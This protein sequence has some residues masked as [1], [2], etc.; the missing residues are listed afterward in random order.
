MSHTRTHYQPAAVAH[1]SIMKPRAYPCDQLGIC[2]C[3]GRPCLNCQPQPASLLERAGLGGLALITLV[4]FA[5][6][7]GWLWGT[8]ER[9]L[10]HLWW[11]FLSLVS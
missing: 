5:G 6:A 4:I 9:A 3:M 2:D 11:S 8:Y 1:T 10:T 7:A